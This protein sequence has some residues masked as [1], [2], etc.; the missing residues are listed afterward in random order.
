MYIIQVILYY[1]NIIL[2][3]IGLYYYFTRLQIYFY[4]THC[5]GDM[6]LKNLRNV[7][8]VHGEAG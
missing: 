6:Y 3:V 2:L 7:L 8:V 5:S 4:L 1:Y